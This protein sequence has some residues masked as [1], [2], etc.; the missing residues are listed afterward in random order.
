MIGGSK[1]GGSL[2]NLRITG[3]GLSATGLPTGAANLELARTQFLLDTYHPQ[4]ARQAKAA[5][6]S[7]PQPA[8]AGP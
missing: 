1:A 5:L 3:M 7:V 2:R 6:R 8:T 4:P